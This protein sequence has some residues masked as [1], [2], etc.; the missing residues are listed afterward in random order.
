[1]LCSP[2]CRHAHARAPIQAGAVIEY[3]KEMLHNGIYLPLL[4][5]PDQCSKDPL[6]IVYTAG[7]FSAA[8]VLPQPSQAAADAKARMCKL[9]RTYD[10]QKAL[11]SP[12]RTTG[13][14]PSNRTEAS[15]GCSKHTAEAASTLP[16]RQCDGAEAQRA[17]HADQH[18]AGADAGRLTGGRVPGVT[19]DKGDGSGSGGSGGG[20]GEAA[21]DVFPRAIYDL[22]PVP[23][24]QTQR[25]AFASCQTAA[26]QLDDEEDDAELQRAIAMSIPPSTPQNAPQP[27]VGTGDT[28]ILSAEE[29]ELQRAIAL[30]MFVCL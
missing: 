18:A 1:V 7:H 22:A 19:Q 30:S 20:G 15:K 5:H 2:G 8:V 17:A 16:C 27:A 29:E 12:P 9:E 28:P 26:T 13:R 11:L 25:D 23:H 6:V 3:P 4:H 24:S 21:D 14:P 10:I